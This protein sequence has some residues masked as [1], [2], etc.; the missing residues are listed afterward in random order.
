MAFSKYLTKLDV[1]RELVGLTATRSAIW[2]GWIISDKA[3]AELL[4]IYSNS[5]PLGLVAFLLPLLWFLFLVTR[6]RNN[7][8]DLTIPSSEAGVTDFQR[9]VISLMLYGLS[10]FA[11]TGV[12]VLV[13]L[14]G[15]HIIVT[16]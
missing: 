13:W 6:V 1:A 11:R 12:C 9:K 4:G 10:V 3:T 16:R 7:C 8:D 2:F 5:M 15:L 14:I